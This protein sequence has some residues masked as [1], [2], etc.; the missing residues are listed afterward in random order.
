LNNRANLM[1]PVFITYV[2]TAFIALIPAILLYK[3]VDPTI[4]VLAFF[5]ITVVLSFWWSWEAWGSPPIS[6][7]ELIAAIVILYM[8]Y[9]VLR[10]L[11]GV[12]ACKFW[13]C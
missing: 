2:L 10:V 12:F 5:V 6:I 1:M 4:G 9:S 13:N 8:L 7:L 3:F 11:G